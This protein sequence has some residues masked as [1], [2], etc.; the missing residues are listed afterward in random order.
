MSQPL[1][2]R[3]C[4]SSKKQVIVTDSALEYPAQDQ[5]DKSPTVQLRSSGEIS[6]HS[7][8]SS[9]RQLRRTVSNGVKKL[10]SELFSTDNDLSRSLEIVYSEGGT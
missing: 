9:P 8:P 2:Y 4:C 10:T 3:S 6:P 7:L 1:K 5:D